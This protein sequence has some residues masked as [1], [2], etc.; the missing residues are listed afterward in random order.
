MQH[1]IDSPID[2]VIHSERESRLRDAIW[3][4]KTELK[5]VFLLRQNGEMTYDQIGEA[6]SMPVGTVK[7]RMRSALKQLRE[8][9]ES[10]EL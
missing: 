7:T 8:A 6:L 1:A 9:M 10:S 3:D 5:E 4:L 2:V